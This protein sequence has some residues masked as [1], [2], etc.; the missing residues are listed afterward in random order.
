[1]NW[2]GRGK[3]QAGGEPGPQLPG[4][5]KRFLPGGSETAFRL[6][7]TLSGSDPATGRRI[8]RSGV[9]VSFNSPEEAERIAE[10]QA[11]AALDAAL[12]GTRGD[13]AAYAYL[14]NRKTEPLVQTVGEASGSARITVNGYGAL[15]LN[16]NQV[17][18]V[19]I[20]A[21]DDGENP[22][23]SDQ[24]S[25]LIDALARHP[26]LQFRTYRTR[27]GWRLLCANQVFDPTSSETQRLLVDLGAD[28][29]YV[30]LCRAQR[31][32]RARLTPKP[33]RARYRPRH[34]AP[35]QG[36]VRAELQR[37]IDHTWRYATARRAG[38]PEEIALEVRPIV[39]L[40]DR[41]T[42]ATSSKPLA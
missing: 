24:P 36:I 7:R 27:G 16:A 28:P 34:D 21:N 22:S 3:K 33:W 8:F 30:V 15:V 19:D 38:G 1:M 12:S 10:A 20:D 17:L 2:F 39:E 40:H 5:Q 29:K 31:S 23:I 13:L 37:Y 35:T 32:F 25:S 6:L 4:D 11:R 9:G 42:Q 18:F 41:W 14:V 26:E